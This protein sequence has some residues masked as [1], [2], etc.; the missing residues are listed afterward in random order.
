MNFKKRVKKYRIGFNVL[1]RFCSST[2]K[3][4][5]RPKEKRVRE[6]KI[7]SK[8]KGAVNYACLKNQNFRSCK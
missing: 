8:G 7:K 3:F 2:P 6:W 5:S 4:N 1:R